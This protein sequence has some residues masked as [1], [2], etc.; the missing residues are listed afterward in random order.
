[1]S[2]LAADPNLI[3]G[4]DPRVP[5]VAQIISFLTGLPCGN[6]PERPMEEESSNQ[7]LLLGAYSIILAIAASSAEIHSYLNCH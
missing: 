3:Q 6:R 4:Y 7:R 5:Y 2:S 1:M